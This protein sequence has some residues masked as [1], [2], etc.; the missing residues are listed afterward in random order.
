MTILRAERNDATAFSKFN[1]GSQAFNSLILNRNQIELAKTAHIINAIPD[2]LDYQYGKTIA[3]WLVA[4]IPRSLW[5]DKPI[6]QP[7]PIIGNKIYDQRRA[8]V[9]PAFIAEM[10]WNFHLP[11]VL[12]GSLLLG[13]SM[14]FL[15]ER[16]RPVRKEG[17]TDP[18]QIFLYVAAPM[19]LGFQAIGSNLGFAMFWLMFNFAIAIVML[20]LIAT[21]PQAEKTSS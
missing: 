6:I 7:G 16:F 11:G 14:R 19:M 5:P 12:I 13:I 3:I 8:G 20:K 17:N 9:P 1:P 21:R 18:S 15:H 10:F 2:K 4:P